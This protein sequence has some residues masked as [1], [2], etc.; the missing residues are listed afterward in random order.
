MLCVLYFTCILFVFL[1]NVVTL[2]ECHSEIKGYLLTYLIA[3]ILH[4]QNA[5]TI[6]NCDVSFANGELHQ[7]CGHVPVLNKHVTKIRILVTCSSAAS[8]DHIIIIIIS[9]FI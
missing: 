4:N 9:V 2:C 8:R 6:P 1:I 5:K 7:A 3:F